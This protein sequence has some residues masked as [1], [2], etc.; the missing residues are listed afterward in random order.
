MYKYVDVDIENDIKK[1]ANKINEDIEIAK[2]CTNVEKAKENKTNIT[3]MYID[4]RKEK[5]FSI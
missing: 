4:L 3:D 1:L 5:I 2:L